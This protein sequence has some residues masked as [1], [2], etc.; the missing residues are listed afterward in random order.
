MRPLSGQSVKTCTKRTFTSVL[1][2]ILLVSNE[3]N[4][5]KWVHSEKSIY[6]KPWFLL[7]HC[8][9]LD[10]LLLEEQQTDE[11]N[12]PICSNAESTSLL[13]WSL[14]VFVWVICE[15]P[16]FI[17]LLLISTL[18]VSVSVRRQFRSCFSTDLLISDRLEDAILLSVVLNNSDC[19]LFWSLAFLFQ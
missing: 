10:L 14:M 12:K 13:S 3:I 5:P 6:F 17:F 11:L 4:A 8:Q 16:S 18:L 2:V 19:H 15:S 1:C 9:N 7:L